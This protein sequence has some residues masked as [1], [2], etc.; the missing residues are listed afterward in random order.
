M[1]IPRHCLNHQLF[2]FLNAVLARLLGQPIN[3]TMPPEDSKFHPKVTQMISKQYLNP[4]P[5][6]NDIELLTS[7]GYDDSL[8]QWCKRHNPDGRAILPCSLARQLQWSI[9]HPPFMYNLQYASWRPFDRANA[10]QQTRV[11]NNGGVIRTSEK[12]VF[13]CCIWQYEGVVLGH[14][15]SVKRPITE[16]TKL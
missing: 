4:F 13:H 5:I 12:E 3:I 11:V 6:N 7:E 9:A 10:S 1:G 8:I 16:I 2:I 14:T 15:T